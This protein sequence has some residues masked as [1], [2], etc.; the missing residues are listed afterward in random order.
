[1]KTVFATIAGV[2][3]AL[4]FTVGT[5]MGGRVPDKLAGPGP[6]PHPPYAKIGVRGIPTSELS[7]VIQHTCLSC[8][9][10]DPQRQPLARGLQR[11]LGL[12]DISETS[13]KMI[14]KLRAEMMPLPALR[15][16]RATRSSARRD[17]RADHRQGV[18][19]EP[20]RAHLPAPEPPRVRARDSRPA[21]HR[22]QRRRLAAARHQEREL[23]QHRR[24]AGAVADAA[25]GVPQRGGR[26][27]PH[28]GRRSQ[29]AADARRPTAS[30]PFTS[31]HPW[32][33]VEGAPYGTRGGI[34]AEHVFP[35]DGMYSFRLN[36]AGGIGTRLEDIDI[37]ID[38]ERVALLDYETGVDRMRRPTRR[39]RRLHQHRA[40]L[41]QGRPATRGGGVRAPR[42]RSVRRSDQ[43]ARLV[44][45]RR[46]HRRAPARPSCRTSSRSRIVGP[47]QDHGHLRDAEP[48]ERSSPAIRPRPPNSAPAPSRSSTR[49][50]TQ[51]YRR[52]LTAHDRDG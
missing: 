49:L 48:Q 2:T 19:T 42:R 6:K 31:Q 51:A 13:E 34:V 7:S 1:M 33:H 47:Q 28:G 17:D 43:A 14:R 26:R 52:P 45:A 5:A 8:H 29:C 44:D 50:G 10:D 40:D 22:R 35:A 25:R 39:R 3:S 46:R 36:V 24:R 23:R 15:V 27:Q 20:G 9:N 4:A 21:R 11:R 41:S 12:R 30:S 18:A 38:G 32:D 37:S 16:R